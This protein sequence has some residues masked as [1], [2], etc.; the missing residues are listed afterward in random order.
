MINGRDQDLL[1]ALGQVLASEIDAAI[2]PLRERIERL[3]QRG[4]K[5]DYQRALP[6]CAQSEVRYKGAT[7]IATRD[8]CA[9]EILPGEPGSGWQLKDK[10]PAPPRQ[11]TSERTYG[12]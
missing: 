10:S 8:V 11:P 4:W 6:Y 9:G 2:K 12:V 7:W 1:A 5:G 3:E